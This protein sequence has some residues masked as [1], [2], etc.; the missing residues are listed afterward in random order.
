MTSSTPAVTSEK[1]LVYPW[2][3]S[4]N[5]DLLWYF[6]PILV[7]IA[8]TYL[9]QYVPYFGTGL[10]MLFVA[11]AFGVG[12]AHQGP[13]W[14]FYF[15]KR[16]R[17]YW[18]ENKK[19]IFI[20]YVAPVM[21]F[22]LSILLAVY[23]PAL[24]LTIMALWGIQHF[25]QQNFGITLLYHNKNN[26]EAIPDRDLL[27]RSLWTPAILFSTMF[28]YHV[29][30]GPALATVDPKVLSPAVISAGA[31]VIFVLLGLLAIFD[32]SRVLLSL[33][34]QVA[35]GARINVPA[36]MFWVVSVLYF[37]P[38]VLPGQKLETVN[39]I[40]GTMHWFQYI[41][42]NMIL[43]EQKYAGEERKRDIPCGAFLLMAI[44]CI[45]STLF[46]LLDRGVQQTFPIDSFN[47][48]V[49]MGVYIGLANVHYYQDAFFWKFR[50]KFQR[51]SIMP[52]LMQA[53]NI[54]AQ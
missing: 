44:L 3:A 26:N 25:I 7:A 16:N 34:K 19:R 23:I 18:A 52:F 24:S 48:R 39:L 42:L 35:G 45:G 22:V 27:L 28:F 50:E 37:V 54:N 47:W 36:F 46:F 11:N 30:F 31:N 12:P 38:Y 9:I 5:F 41:G 29:L 51:D 53:R 40:N 14:F 20:Y 33:R 13:T 32:V 15:D 6:A 49:L 1:I 10:L 8:A 2:M 17:A 43:I 21:V 4:R